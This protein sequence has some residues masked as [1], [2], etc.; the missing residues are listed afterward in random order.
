MIRAIH[1]S[2][3]CLA[4]L[5]AASI[6]PALSAC[7]EPPDDGD[8]TRHPD[9]TPVRIDSAPV[10]QLGSADGSARAFHRVRTP[11]LADEGE[12]VVPTAGSG[13]IRVF[14][15]GGEL[16][17]TLGGSGQGPGEFVWLDGAWPRGD[18]IEAWD[19][20]QRRLTRFLPDGSV[21]VVRFE[22]VSSAQ[23]VVPAPLADGWIAT[24]I[25]AAV[26]GRRDRMLFHR[27]DT[28]GAHVDTVARTLGMRRMETDLI[29]GPDP[30]SP[31]AVFD[32]SDGRLYV[33]ETTTP[34]LRVLSADGDSL[35]TFT[36]DPG[37][38]P[39]PE[40][41]FRTVVDSAVARAAADDRERERK[42]LESF[43]VADDV[44]VFWSVL[45]DEPGFVWIQRYD[46]ARHSLH[47][48]G[49]PAPAGAGPGGE[50]IVLSPEGERVATVEMP[51]GLRPTQITNDRVIG[52]RRTELGLETVVVHRLVR[53]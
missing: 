42:I 50:W 26:M 32:L 7:S 6:L 1:A 51:P 24:G 4:A 20:K 14:G 23:R 53:R 22:S 9:G 47:T 35:G 18:A 27:F 36:W 31:R 8:R 16:R 21:E 5:T 46:P 2:C 3:R 28:A 13:E 34:E 19:W 45:V 25:G 15:P 30:L 39:D 10:R 38:T 48:G 33:G 41:A 40:R 17:R 43:P 52:I 49:R 12:L 37:S 29:G 11:F 44:S